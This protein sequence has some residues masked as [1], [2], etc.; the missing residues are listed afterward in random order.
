VS[1]STRSFEDHAAGRDVLYVAARAPRPGFTKSRL[2]R[3]IGH[4]RAATL[5]GTFVQDLAER[6]EAAP[7]AV[8]WYVTPDDA[9]ID[10]APLMPITRESRGNRRL[11]L[12]QPPGDWTERQRA[13]FT[14]ARGRNERRTVLIASDSPQLDVDLIG[15]AFD[16]LR[17]DDIVLG[18]TVDGGYYL[19]GVRS[20][21]HQTA[22]C[23]WDVLSDVRMSTGTELYEILTRATRLGLRSSLLPLDLR[24]RRGGRSRWSHPAGPRARW[25][26]CYPSGTCKAGPASRLDGHGQTA[27][28]SRD[29]RRGRPMSA[30]Q[31]FARAGVGLLAGLVGGLA[32][33]LTMLVL[34]LLVGVSPPLEMI[35]D[36]FAPT[37]SIDQFLGLI[38]RF[39]GYNELK[40]FGVSSVLA[41]QLVVAGLLGVLYALIPRPTSAPGGSIRLA[42]WAGGAARLLVAAIALLWI[43][44]LT[45]LWHTLPTSFIGLPPSNAAPV[46]TTGLLAAYVIY[47]S[48]LV[49][50]YRGM[51]RPTTVASRTSGASA[52]A[53]RALLV[54]GF[55]AVLGIAVAAIGRRL[56]DMA[57]FAYDGTRFWGPLAPIT[58]NDQ[59][60]VVTKNV[61][62]PSVERGI[63]RLDVGGNVDRPHTYTFDEIASLPSIV[64]E[65]TSMCISNVVGD[66]L[67]SNARWTGVPLR[68]LLETAGP[69]SRAVEVLLR[70]RAAGPVPIASVQR[71]RPGRCRRRSRPPVRGGPPSRA[72]P[73]NDRW[74]PRPCRG[75]LSGL[76]R[77]GRWRPDADLRRGRVAPGPAVAGRR[78]SRRAPLRV[79]HAPCWRRHLA[80]HRHDAHFRLPRIADRRSRT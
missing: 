76:G 47:G 70:G 14:N 5:Y 24:C 78:A 30:G 53:R 56:W 45:I 16:R 10:L 6:L 67:M 66:A 8:G 52:P 27:I 68:T 11:I 49:L 43:A 75:R 34:R 35:P 13:L 69:Q 33:T 15:E 25:S 9:W 64:Q 61:V 1:P 39:G 38:G 22:A 54:T 28:T 44:S 48:V 36:R 72:H 31:P 50:T 29:C 21:L 46:T 4:E 77:H 62:D 7:F 51:T 79:D 26:S 2:G 18:P 65:T 59:F 74:H 57:C 37:M 55:G 23:P 17:R 12:I 41:G 60:Y 63:W 42:R 3:A 19:I 20:T 80:T 58:P 32:M 40:Q 73:N 71:V